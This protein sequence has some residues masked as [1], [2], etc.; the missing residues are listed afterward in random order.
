MRRIKIS[1][2]FFIFV[3]AV[4]VNAQTSVHKNSNE[5]TIVS[6]TITTVQQTNDRTIHLADP[7]IF[8]N[9]GTYYLY[10]INFIWLM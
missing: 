6:T 5:T 4:A 8:Y 10:G 1:I 2:M 9:R 3:F 7:T